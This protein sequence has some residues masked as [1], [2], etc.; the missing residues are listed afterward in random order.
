MLAFNLC[1]PV[2]YDPS[3]TLLSMLPS[4]AASTVALSLLSRQRIGLRSLLVG[5][6]L[7]GAGI[8]AMHYTGMAAMHLVGTVGY[9]KHLVAASVLIA[10]VAATVALWFTTA[11]DS[12]W[13]RTLAAAIMGVAVTAMHYT[14][15]SATRIHLA[16]AFAPPP[17]VD[18]VLLVLPITLIA[19]CSIIGLVLMALQTMAQEDH[20]AP[21]PTATVGGRAR[22]QSSMPDNPLSHLPRR[23]IPDRTPA[24]LATLTANKARRRDGT[25]ATPGAHLSRHRG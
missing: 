22:A 24:S 11:V 17:G 15:M 6:V 8:G 9:D 1:T 19:A 12:R 20:D 23:P 7:V 25:G 3:I 21:L 18:P 5:G 4:V 2:S 13:P 16:R 10:V 14:A